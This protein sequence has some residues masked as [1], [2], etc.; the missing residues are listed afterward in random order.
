MSLFF[1]IGNYKKENRKKNFDVFMI[2][3]IADNIIYRSNV[4]HMLTS[5][6]VLD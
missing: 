2:L 3:K 4:L 6:G 5:Y 1:D